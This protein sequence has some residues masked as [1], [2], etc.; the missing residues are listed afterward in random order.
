MHSEK[1]RAYWREWNKRH[2]EEIR[3]R[4]Y[5]RYQNDAEYREKKQKR[6]KEFARKHMQKIC[7]RVALYRKLHP[8]K[9]KVQQIRSTEKR[10]IERNKCFDYLG[11]KCSRCGYDESRLALQFHHRDRSKKTFEISVAIGWNWTFE[12]LKPELDKC[13]ILCANCHKIVEHEYHVSKQKVKL[14]T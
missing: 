6:S 11:G 8:E 10:T 5:E 7:D 1:Q 12:S 4:D 3:K 2:R 9:V 14:E 13:V